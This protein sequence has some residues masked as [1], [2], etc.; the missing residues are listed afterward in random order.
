MGVKMGGNT[1]RQKLETKTEGKNWRQKTGRQKYL[2][3]NVSLHVL[4]PSVPQLATTGLAIYCNGKLFA[5]LERLYLTFSGDNFRRLS[6]TP[7]CNVHSRIIQLR[8]QILSR[9]GVT[10]LDQCGEVSSPGMLTT[11]WI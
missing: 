5:G 11:Y 6:V 3:R 2:F 4:G 1:W 8:A 10:S 9:D 7:F